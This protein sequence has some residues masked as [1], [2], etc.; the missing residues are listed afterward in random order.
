MFIDIAMPYLRQQK[1]DRV[2]MSD[3]LLQTGKFWV[4]P[5]G[6][7]KCCLAYI[8]NVKLVSLRHLTQLKVYRSSANETCYSQLDWN[9]WP[10]W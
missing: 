3:I 2:S 7:N 10:Q 5:E 1:G 8:G 9:P 6:G 4:F